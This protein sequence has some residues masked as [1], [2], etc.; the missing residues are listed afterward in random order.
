M[1]ENV[2]I[3]ISKLSNSIHDEDFIYISEDVTEELEET[4]NPF[5][6]VEPILRLMECNPD[7]DF[8]VPG[9]LVHFV[10]K[11]YKNG[12]EEKLLDSLKRNPTKHTIWMLNRI[13]N[14]S[15][16][17]SKDLYIK[18]MKEILDSNKTGKD[19]KSLIEQFLS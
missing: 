16:E 2:R 3:L 1:E 7:V 5:D 10:E 11:F 13:I 12:Y 19:I 9:A 15:D 17:E 6:A 18:I 8:G 4:Q 14:G